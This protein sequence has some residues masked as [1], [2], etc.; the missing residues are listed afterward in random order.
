[1]AASCGDKSL[2]LVADKP[3]FLHSLLAIDSAGIF[4]DVTIVIRDEAQQ[5]EIERYLGAVNLCAKVSCVQ[6]G[7]SRQKSVLNA[8]IHAQ[9]SRPDFVLIH[10]A[11]RPLI[12]KDCMHLL[13]SAL[14]DHDAAV[15]A[16]KATDTLMDVSGDKRNYLLRD[17]IWHI[18]TPQI[19]RY[20]VILD[21]YLKAKGPL[22]DDSSALPESTRMKIIEN[23]TPNI[24]ITYPQDF[25]TVKALLS[26]NSVK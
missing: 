8:L 19:F 13:L 17:T 16:H 6:G 18:E 11:A 4:S 22:T 5:R 1:M 21:A 10:D 23:F 24:K 12:A 26:S 20:E 9:H 7:D 15:L 25:A 2:A 14:G 3:V